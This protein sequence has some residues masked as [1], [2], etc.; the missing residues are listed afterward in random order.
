[1]CRDSKGY[2]WARGVILE[3]PS[4][5]MTKDCDLCDEAG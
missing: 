4:K 2:E 3:A 1:M 5:G